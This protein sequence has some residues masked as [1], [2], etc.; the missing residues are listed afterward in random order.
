MT[1]QL[2]PVLPVQANHFQNIFFPT[3]YKR[4]RKQSFNLK[5]IGIHQQMNH[6]L[7][8]VRI[9]STNIGADEDAG[10]GGRLCLAILTNRKECQQEKILSD[11]FFDN[12]I[13]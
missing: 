13:F 1:F 2:F 11:D 8:I 6:G 5:P 7:V 12:D 4:S 10:F 9:R 3:F